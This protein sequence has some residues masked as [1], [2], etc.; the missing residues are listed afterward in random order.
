MAIVKA[1]YTSLV[2]SLALQ[3]LSSVELG[4]SGIAEDRR[5]HLIDGGGRLLTQ[6]QRPRLALVTASFDSSEGHL[7]LTFPDDGE[8]AGPV[9]LGEP[10][11]TMIWGRPTPGN[12]VE[13]GWGLSRLCSGP[14]R[15]VM[16]DQPGHSFDEYPVSV[17]TQ[18]S[19]D[20]MSRLTEGKKEFEARRFRPTLL[21][22][23]AIPH[24]EDTWLGKQV[25]VGDV[26]RIRIAAPDGRCAI[27]AVDPDSGQ[28]D[29]DTPRFLR[30]YRPSG[31]APYFGVYATV[32]TPGVV[33]VGDEVVPDVGAEPG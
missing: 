2:K 7:S 26:A 29:F 32:E 33:S 22:E 30:A 19:V 24:E 21:L 11:R 6:R 31:R 8:I 14:V 18:E 27:T 3:S 17:L 16:T 5:F 15:L 13:G 4:L 1:I 12:V 20:L 28:R 10:V 9:R 23:G 25:A